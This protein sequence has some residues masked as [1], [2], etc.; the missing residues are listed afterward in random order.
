MPAVNYNG[1][2][3]SDSII[4]DVLQNLC[5][6]F[7]ANVNVKSGDRDTVPKGGSKES[8]HLAYQAADFHVEGEDDGVVYLHLR[9]L[10]YNS[11]L[12]GGN[13]YEFIWHGPFTET[14]GQHL[15]IGRYGKSAIGYVNFIKEGITSE[16]KNVYTTEIKLPIV[17]MFGL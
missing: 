1:H 3:I 15:H 10:G 8:L 12:K 16:G 14:G 9:N 4:K 2:K 11:V 17:P 7:Q 6:Y 5:D 13:G